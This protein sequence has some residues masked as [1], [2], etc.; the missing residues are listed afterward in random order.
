MGRRSLPCLDKECPSPRHKKPINWVG[1]YA[2]VILDRVEDAPGMWKPGRRIVL[3]VNLAAANGLTAYQSLARVGVTILKKEGR[4]DWVLES[5]RQTPGQRE[6][7]AD[8]PVEDVLMRLWGIRPPRAVMPQ[9]SCQPDAQD[10]DS[11]ESYL[12]A[13][14]EWLDANNGDVPL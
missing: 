6:L 5:T 9:R 14:R 11:E 4:K 3:P 1:Y 13:L 8:F 7:P 12:E 2:A 10:Y